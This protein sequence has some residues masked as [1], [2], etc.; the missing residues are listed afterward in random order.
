MIVLTLGRQKVALIGDGAV[1]SAYAFALM[2]QGLA[3]ELV[4]IDVDKDRTTGDALDLEDAAVF[5]SP[6]KVYSGDYS[7]CADADLVIL[8][9]GAAQKPGETRLDLVDKNLKITK[10]IIDPLMESG[11]D[12][13]IVVAANPVDILTYAA[14]KFSG[15]P[16]NR[17]I[18]SGTSLDSS[19]LRVALSKK[20]NVSPQSIEAYMM[21]EHGDSEF[22][23]YS[24]S[25][26]G[27][28]PVLD[29]A[30]EIGLTDKDLAEIEDKTIHKAY[31]I[32]NTKGATFYGVSTCLIRITKAILRDENA[33]IPV[34]APVDGEY[35]LTDLY[36]GTPA[37]INASGI[38]NVIE[39]PLTDE[40]QA[41]MTASAKTLR[42]II[43]NGMAK[44]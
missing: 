38:A 4:I 15:L 31:G 23:A 40:E 6:K 26:V 1:G 39:V 35:G 14:Q 32:I 12:G 22:A 13:I 24:I 36:I 21:G 18:S 33:I 29:V 27:G 41:R 8:T 44:F 2:H 19:R 11:F 28:R 7:D 3:E 30:K 43:D 37:V 42:E 25:T 5:T 9:A 34:G 10:S 16:K 17:V 20:F